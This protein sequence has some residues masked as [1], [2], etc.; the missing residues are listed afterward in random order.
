MFKRNTFFV[1]WKL[2]LHTQMQPLS[3]SVHLYCSQYW[4]GGPAGYAERERE[5]WWKQLIGLQ[6]NILMFKPFDSVQTISDLSILAELPSKNQGSI[7]FGS[8]WLEQNLSAWPSLVCMCIINN[9]SVTN[10]EQFSIQ[11]LSI[12]EPNGVKVLMRPHT[13][14]GDFCKV[15]V[16]AGKWVNIKF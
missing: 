3:S 4:E 7:H 2:L 5:R 16:S 10:N 12:A 9:N 1:V 15:L 8:T 13:S 6:S 11:A 14:F